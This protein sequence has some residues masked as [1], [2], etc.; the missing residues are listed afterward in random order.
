M[1]NLIRNRHI[2]SQSQ[3]NST[4]PAQR[5]AQVAALVNCTGSSSA[6]TLACMRSVPLPVLLKAELDFAAQVA[7]PFGFNAL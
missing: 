4:I 7:P 2:L 6:D 3:V 1:E 5:F